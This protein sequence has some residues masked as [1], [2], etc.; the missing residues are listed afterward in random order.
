MLYKNQTLEKYLFDLGAKLPAPGGGSAAALN[1]AMG[2]ALI[3]M[4]VN[5]SLGKPACA[6]FDAELKTALKKS[7]R[8]RND[9]LGLVDLDVAAYQSKDPRKAMDVPLMVARLCYEGIKLLPALVK[10]S[11]VNLA[12]DLGEAAI[13]LES[14]F[15]AAIFNVEINLKIIN[16]ARLTGSINKELRLKEKA[17]KRIRAA[18][19][20]KVGK[21]I[22]R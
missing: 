10:Q 2:A 18:V 9:F 4:A 20:G 17:V 22:R 16:D 15:C 11:N 8:L 6:G 1:A 12:S 19:E 3:G 21:I 14:A 7:E 13:F 5:F